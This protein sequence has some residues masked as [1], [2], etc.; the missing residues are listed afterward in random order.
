MWTE[1]ED[2]E[3]TTMNN[4]K[5]HS[6]WVIFTPSAASSLFLVLSSSQN[7]SN[8]ISASSLNSSVKTFVHLSFLAW[9][10]FWKLA[11]QCICFIRLLIETVLWCV[12]CRKSSVLQLKASVEE[13]VNRDWLLFRPNAIFRFYVSEIFY[14]CEFY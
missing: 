3:V 14:T 1:T 11:V 5:L 6:C 8:S 4:K 10:N 7:K 13:A 12:Y 2:M 9:T